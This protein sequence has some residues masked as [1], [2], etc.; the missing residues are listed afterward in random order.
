[1]RPF[2]LTSGRFSSLMALD[3]AE[4]PVIGEIAWFLSTDRVSLTA[5][6]PGLARDASLSRRGGF[7]PSA[8]RSRDAARAPPLR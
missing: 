1:L 5:A 2:S 8:D 7:R 4:A 3:R 6:L